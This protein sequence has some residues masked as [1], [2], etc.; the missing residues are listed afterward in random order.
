MGIALS[1]AHVLA[2]CGGGGKVGFIETDAGG[3][4]DTDTD[5]DSDADSDS[6]SDTDTDTGTGTGTDTDTDTETGTE[7]EACRF[8]VVSGDFVAGSYGLLD[9][10]PDGNASFDEIGAS[11]SD[12]QARVEGDWVFVVGRAGSNL[13]VLDP[14]DLSLVR[15]FSV[16]DAEGEYANP[17][18][19]CLVSD[20]EAYV[21]RYE[22]ST[23]AIVDP[24]AGTLDGTVDLG[25]FADAD[26]IGEAESCAVATVKDAIY[27]YVALQ[28]LDRDNFYSCAAGG[29][30]LA[31][32]DT[33]TGAIVDRDLVEGGLQGI[34]LAACNPLGEARHDEAAG[35][36]YLAEVG[37]FGVLD[38]GIEAIDLVAM[39]SRGFVVSEE[40]LGDDVVG[41]ALIA[42]D[43]GLA[44]LSTETF[45]TVLAQFDPEA[46]TLGDAIYAPGGYVI[47]DVETCGDW[48]VVADRTL[49]APGVVVIDARTG[50]PAFDSPLDTGLP[51]VDIAR[52]P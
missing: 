32:V 20:D 45:Q 9:V 25:S 50:V 22:Q 52:L 14:D 21:P 24:T 29:S 33:A 34:P 35:L 8:L 18:D 19:V 28:R 49:D 10:Q 3:D 13:T 4:S 40:A 31:V 6:D 44:I 16:A 1:L 36:L 5:G 42:D 12:P 7:P 15:Q 43:L 11:D 37:A 51:P 17:H 48:A 27:A 39:G 41:F 23:V 46:G 30:V 26:G 38:G 47:S 2:G